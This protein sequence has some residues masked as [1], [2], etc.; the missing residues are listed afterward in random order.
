L[1]VDVN[2]L[3]T[4]CILNSRRKKKETVEDTDPIKKKGSDA[5]NRSFYSDTHSDQEV[6]QFSDAADD[7]SFIDFDKETE[8]MENL[9]NIQEEDGESQSSFYSKD[10]TDA[11]LRA[12]SRKD[13][14]DNESEIQKLTASKPRKKKKPQQKLKPKAASNKT[15]NKEKLRKQKPGK[16]RKRKVNKLSEPRSSEFDIEDDEVKPMVYED[17]DISFLLLSKSVPVSKEYLQ[18]GYDKDQEHVETM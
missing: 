15:R 1:R 14:V 5:E 9:S 13:S 10:S 11:N 4:S 3:P 17:A 2:N 8:D 16:D 18:P 12:E 6:D 7:N